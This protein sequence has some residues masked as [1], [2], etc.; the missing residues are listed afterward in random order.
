MLD[1]I[2]GIDANSTTPPS[3]VA[4][5]R[6]IGARCFRTAATRR[7]AIRSFGG[8]LVVKSD[9]CDYCCWLYISGLASR[10]GGI[11]RRV[12]FK[13]RF[14]QGSEGS[15]PSFGNLFKAILD[16]ELHGLR[17]CGL[18]PS[19]NYTAQARN[20]WEHRLSADSLD[21]APIHPN[22][23]PTSITNAVPNSLQHLSH[24]P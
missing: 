7:M 14:S 9:L 21:R 15:S 1:S 12:G 24:T 23:V 6:S 20:S 17:R 13:I 3:A 10:S 18:Q 8:R 4:S 22:Q 2:T 11:G 19:P 16:I 5:I